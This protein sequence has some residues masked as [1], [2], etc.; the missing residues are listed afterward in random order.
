MEA[1]L[2]K[3]AF[4]DHGGFDSKI[5]IWIQTTQ[6]IAYRVVTV[7]PIDKNVL[8]E[9][10]T[11]AERFREALRLLAFQLHT[12][13]TRSFWFYL[14]TVCTRTSSVPNELP[15]RD[16]PGRSAR[17][18]QDEGSLLF[19]RTTTPP[20][21]LQHMSPKDLEHQQDKEVSP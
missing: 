7:M 3:K 4:E 16:A 2:Q 11:E 17:S 6:N 13:D 1:L 10:Q 8:N 20:S 18:D 14:D 12:R 15:A 9:W 21:R 5:L 19:C